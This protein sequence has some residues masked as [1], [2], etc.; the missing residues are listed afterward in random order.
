VIG[1][2]FSLLGEENQGRQFPVTNQILLYPWGNSDADTTKA[3]YKFLV[4]DMQL[5]LKAILLRKRTLIN[6]KLI[7]DALNLFQIISK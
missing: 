5:W 3:N 2:L 4:T 6:Y 7:E 1:Y